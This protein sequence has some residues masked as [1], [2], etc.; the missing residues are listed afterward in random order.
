LPKGCDAEDGWEDAERDGILME[1]IVC[2]KRIKIVKR[3]KSFDFK[4]KKEYSRVIYRCIKDDVW[5]V[6]EKPKK[7]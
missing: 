6:V 2:E 1:C 5:I 4:K 3:D 7:K